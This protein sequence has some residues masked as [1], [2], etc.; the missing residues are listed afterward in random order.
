MNPSFLVQGVACA[1]GA[2]LAWGLVFVV[3]LMLIDY[4]PML[5]SVGRYLAFGLIALPLAL[6]D[7]SRLRQLDRQDWLRALELALIGNLLYYGL[8]AAAIQLA[9]AP[10]PTMLIGTLPIV[11]AVS[12]NFGEKA[13]AWRRLLPSLLV[14]ACGILL[15]NRQEMMRIDAS[16]GLE[17]YLLGGAL[18]IGAVACWTWYPIR[19]ARWLQARPHLASGTWATAQGLATLPLALIGFAAVSALQE[20]PSGFVWPLGPD[21]ARFIGLMLTL[22]LLSSWLGTLLWNRAS[23]LLPTTLSGQLIVFETLAA[24]AYAFWWRGEAPGG[25]TL[26]GIVLLVIGVM[27]GMRSVSRVSRVRRG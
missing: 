5:L 15:V 6:R 2:G 24:L 10:F 13:L 3:P 22:G 7:G 16:C 27:L 11:I 26:A 1:L 18:A 21:P 9:D 23:K 17:Q 8:L 25:V 19:N 12:S 4:P 14:I 20:A